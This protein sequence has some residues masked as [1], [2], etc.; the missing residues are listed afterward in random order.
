LTRFGDVLAAQGYNW[1]ISNTSNPAPARPVETPLPQLSGDGPVLAAQDASDVFKAFTQSAAVTGAPARI[2]TIITL[3]DGM[4]DPNLQQNVD[5]LNT[6]RQGIEDIATAS[7]PTQTAA[8]RAADATAAAS[9]GSGT[10]PG[11]NS[12]LAAVAAL[13]VKL[14]SDDGRTTNPQIQTINENRCGEEQEW[15]F[16]EGCHPIY[17]YEVNVKAVNPNYTP[18]GTAP[19]T[20]CSVASDGITCQLDHKHD[21]SRTVTSTGALTVDLTLGALKA[22]RQ[23]SES[24]ADAETVSIGEVGRTSD[25]LKKG[26]SFY[27]YP[28]YTQVL[29]EVVRYDM[30]TG[31]YVST[32]QKEALFPD[33]TM[34]RIGKTG[35]A[36]GFPGSTP[37]ILPVEP[38]PFRPSPH[39]N[40]TN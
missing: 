31:Q 33:G 30:K 9:A 15:S 4:K 32:E 10:D 6:L 35:E 8:P 36:N 16:S 11:A 14:I 25:P 24:V 28:S 7:L 3:L 40:G 23:I 34:Y 38:P 17:R 13:P 19:Y 26:E 5:H 1:A 21:V 18:P 2:N 39:G 37:E 20:S 12:A 29:Y 22:S 27:A